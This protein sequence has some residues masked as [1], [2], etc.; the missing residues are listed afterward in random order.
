MKF[1]CYGTL[2]VM[3]AL[4]VST[5]AKPSYYSSEPQDDAEVAHGIHF[6][7]Y[8]QAV[9]SGVLVNV[10]S[11]YE[12]CYILHGIAFFNGYTCIIW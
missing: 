7:C 12:C 4:L 1:V 5:L 10:H 2:L 9:C 8:L 11:Y 3:L 6:L